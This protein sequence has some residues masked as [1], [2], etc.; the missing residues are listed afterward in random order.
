MSTAHAVS[1][2]MAAGGMQ[3]LETLS[4][5]SCEIGSEGAKALAAAMTAASAAGRLRLVKLDV[6]WN[7]TGAE[8]AAALARALPLCAQLATLD[9]SQRHRRR[10]CGCVG[11]DAAVVRAAGHAG[12][13]Q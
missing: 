5:R 2:A 13:E 6:G 4:L 1:I 11:D 12:R 8:G 10:G 7:S 9:V 3:R